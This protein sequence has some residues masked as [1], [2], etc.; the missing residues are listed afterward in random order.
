[1]IDQDRKEV[2]KQE[3]PIAVTPIEWKLLNAFTR[4][5]QKVFTREDLIELAFGL[6]FSGYD[7]VIDT[8]VKNLRKKL[9]DDPKQPVY[10]CTVH[11]MGYKFGGFRE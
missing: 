1:M 6:D 4:Y 5:P 3:K 9:E 8:H 7:R 11:G 10:I 2:C